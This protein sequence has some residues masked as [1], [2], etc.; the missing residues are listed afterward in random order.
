MQSQ[1]KFRTQTSEQLQ[2][3]NQ[4]HQLRMA[5]EQQQADRHIKKRSKS[6]LKTK[7]VGPK[8]FN[9]NCKFD[10]FLRQCH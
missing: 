3:L 4:L 2:D 9:T 6:G 7:G 5:D 8:K 10:M 1:L